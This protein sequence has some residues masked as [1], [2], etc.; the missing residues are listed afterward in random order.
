MEEIKK[1][2]NLYDLI[3]ENDEFSKI[4]KKEL[5]N[6]LKEYREEWEKE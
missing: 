6:L 1:K 3:A 2:N 4:M 5:D